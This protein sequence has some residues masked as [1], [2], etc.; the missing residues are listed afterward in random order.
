M[1]YPEAPG[2]LHSEQ[3]QQQQQAAF[4]YKNVSLYR[5]HTG[6]WFPPAAGGAAGRGGITTEEM[7]SCSQLRLL[8]ET[9]K[10]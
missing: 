5:T 3:Q 8:K 7:A 2:D 9:F 4:F 10:G 1:A 6:P